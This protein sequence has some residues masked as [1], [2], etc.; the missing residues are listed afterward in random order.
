MTLTADDALARAHAADEAWARG[1]WWGP[2][3]GVPCTIKDTFEVAGVRTTAG[4]TS[5]ANNIPARD[6]VVAARYRAAGAV[7]IGK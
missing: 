2:F 3:H 1:Q 7:I 5:L 6:A 4:S